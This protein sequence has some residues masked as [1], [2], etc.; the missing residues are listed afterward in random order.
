MAFKDNT[1]ADT[2]AANEG[3]GKQAEGDDGQLLNG[4]TLNGLLMLTEATGEA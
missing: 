3:G 4:N 1:N 2:T